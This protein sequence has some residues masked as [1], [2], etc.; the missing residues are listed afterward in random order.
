[1]SE[2]QSISIIH[3]VLLLVLLSS[4]LLLHFRNRLGTAIKYAAIWIVIILALVVLYSYKH[5]F[6][7]FKDRLIS[8]LSPSTVIKNND[9]SISVK[10]S[11]NGHFNI[12]TKVNGH[13]VRFLIDTGASDVV[14]DKDTARKIGINVDELLFINTYYTANGTV[15]GAP[16]RLEQIKV[17]DYII[18][19]VKASVNEADMNKSLLGMSFLNRLN[20]YEV[21]KDKLTLWP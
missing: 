7:D 21:K 1:M 15:K 13:S 6:S 20:G 14:I 12:N 9:G 17:G 4:A 8:A 3:S 11:K 5:D 16:I 18:R 19:D 10:A 2:D